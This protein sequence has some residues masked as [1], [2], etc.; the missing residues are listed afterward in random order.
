MLTTIPLHPVLLPGIV[1]LLIL[2]QE[3]VLL[4]RKRSQHQTSTRV[5]R[6]SLA[7]L[8]GINLASIVLAIPFGTYHLPP[9]LHFHMNYALILVIVVLLCA[10]MFLRFWSVFTLGAYFTVN[11]AIHREHR[12][13]SHGPYALVRHPS[14]TG[15]LLELLALAVSYQHVVSLLII[16]VPAIVMVLVRIAIEEH[17]LKAHLGHEYKQYHHQTYALVPYLY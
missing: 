3:L 4:A 16:M 17:I 8:W 2:L 13:V 11:V 14:Y 9:E 12:V 6:S 5:D 15:L 1:G 10:G 7:L